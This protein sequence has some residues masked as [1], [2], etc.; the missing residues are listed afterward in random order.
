[1]L[2]YLNAPSPID[3]EG[4]FDTGDRVEVDGEWIRFLGRETDIVNVGGNKVYPS[5]VESVL[6]L[7]DN[8]A[9]AVVT[10][11][12]HPLVGQIVVATVRLI[13]SEPLEAFKH[14]MRC[15]VR[16]RLPSFKS[17]ARVRVTTEALHSARFKRTTPSVA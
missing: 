1:M 12:P 8:V 3:A 7:M 16:D 4:F 5:E 2:G 10:G 15:F 9:E 17:P 11:E 14:R 13:D 6:L